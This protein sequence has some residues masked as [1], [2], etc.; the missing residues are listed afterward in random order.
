MVA[1][2]AIIHASLN[3]YPPRAAEGAETKDVIRPAR[4]ALAGWM[5][6]A[7]GAVLSASSLIDVNN[8]AKTTV[9]TGGTENLLSGLLGA[10]ISSV[11]AFV[12]IVV[13]VIAQRRF[14]QKQIDA[15]R[16]AT[17]D[18]IRAQT[19][20]QAQ[21]RRLHA[22]ADVMSGFFAI[23]NGL[24]QEDR[25]LV[26]A[27]HMNTMQSCMRWRLDAG[28][29]APFILEI[30]FWSDTVTEGAYNSIGMV[31]TASPK[32]RAGLASALREQVAKDVGFLVGQIGS[33]FESEDPEAEARYLRM[34]RRELQE[35]IYRG[36]IED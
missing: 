11:V 14:T 13:T 8:T 35:W 17:D 36:F 5:S 28:A 32:D 31:E 2:G 19:S 34:Q 4:W 33:H 10:V 20:E 22:A 26:R 24:R 16:N 23:Q 12:V 18:Q 21:N 3:L 15:Q 7:S 29:H 9:A 1:L 30:M 27:A 6:I 25:D